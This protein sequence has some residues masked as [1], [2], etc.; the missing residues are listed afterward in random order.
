VL[1]A[2]LMGAQ[3][4]CEYALGGHQVVLHARD[5]A[6]AWAR[7][8]TALSFLEEQRLRPARE[9][10]ATAAR[11]ETAATA[12]EAATGVDLIV[13]SLPENLELK[14]SIL[15]AALAEAPDAVVATNTS[16]LSIS[17]IGDAVGVPEQT[18]G[19]HYLNPPLLMPLVETVAG[20]RT[21]PQTIDFTPQSSEASPR[22][23]PDR[24]TA[25]CRCSPAA[26]A[27]RRSFACAR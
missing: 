3:I 11:L 13:E 26:H 27:P 1:G 12:E 10:N 23:P 8:R 9:L 20:R 4:G 22:R 2:G 21:A 16:S 14:A 15:R 24:T 5:T 7:A 6:A 17:A 25:A 18:V 19:T